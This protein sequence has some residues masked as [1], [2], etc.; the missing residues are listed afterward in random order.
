MQTA[1][2][3]R[4][5][6][7]IFQ[8]PSR[9]HGVRSGALADGVLDVLKIAAGDEEIAASAAIETGRTR[10]VVKSAAVFFIEQ[11]LLFPEADSYRV[12]GG[13]PSAPA[14]DLRRNMALLMR[15]LHPDTMPDHE[16]AVFASRISRAW[17]DVKTSERRAE[18][19]VGRGVSKAVMA[20]SKHRDGG[21]AGGRGSRDKRI[22]LELAR[23]TAG[24]QRRARAPGVLRRLVWRLLATLRR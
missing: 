13:S 20:K 21:R 22:H 11:V 19:D 3:L 16:R 14:N 17:N 7:D 15:W 12:L 24:G 1:D 8:V 4:Q 9:V 6:I 2:A 5:A 23:M 10:D 18:Y